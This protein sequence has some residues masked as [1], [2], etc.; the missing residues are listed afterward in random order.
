MKRLVIS[1]CVGVFLLAASSRGH[2]QTREEKERARKL[3][4]K[5]KALFAKKNYKKAVEAFKAAYFFWKRKEI[6]FNIALAYFNLDKEIQAVTH[7]R[8][9]LEKCTTEERKLVPK[10][11]MAL[12]QKVGVL[13]VQMPKDEAEIWVNGRLEGQG[14]VELVVMPGEMKVAIKVDNEQVAKKS[15]QVDAG[16]QKVWE[17]TT[18][19]S[20]APSPGGGNGGA[21]VGGG[22]TGGTGGTVK[23]KKGIGRLH[24]AYFTAAAGLTV[25]AGA[26]VAGM[27]VKTLQIKDDY[28]EKGT[29]SLEKKGKNFKLGTNVMI[30]VTAAAGVAAAVLAV[31]TNWSGDEDEK[32]TSTTK[33]TPMVSPNSVGLSV[34]W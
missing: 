10:P 2:A 14:R 19:P 18:I 12:Q 16:T 25:V 26:V 21:G 9:Y 29:D 1:V 20:K 5:G 30:G 33:V 27:G 15:I 31:F 32:P 17:L 11:L 22:T 13:I 28:D 4:I 23:K 34:T 8:R 24:W 3:F 7:L 6:Q